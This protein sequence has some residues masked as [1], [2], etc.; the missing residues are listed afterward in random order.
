MIR[1]HFQTWPSL[2]SIVKKD[3]KKGISLNSL[4]VKM[5]IPQPTLWRIV[6][7]KSNGSM[8]VYKKIYSYYNRGGK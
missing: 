4:A 3:L 2:I 1:N 6:N 5:K 8:A 7:E